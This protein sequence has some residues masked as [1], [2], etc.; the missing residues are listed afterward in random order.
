MTKK[1]G[2][3]GVGNMATAIIKG[4][5]G[6]EGIELYGVGHNKAN[7]E[8][9]KSSCSLNIIGDAAEL[10][11]RC[12]YVVIAVKP[13]HAEPVVK[14]IA[15]EMNGDK[16]LISVCAGLT[17]AIFRDWTEGR[18]PIVRVMPNTPALVGEGVAS[19]C[20]EDKKLSAEMKAFLPEVF[21]G[22]GQ[23]HVLPEKLFDAFSSVAGS[24][25]AYVFYFIE[26][27][28]ESGVTLGLARPQAT[29]MVKGLFVGSA[30]LA[31]ESDR[32]VSE[33]REM[34]TSPGGTTARALLH[35]DRQAIRG[36]IIDGV[37]KAYLR[38]IELGEQ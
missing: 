38:N 3:I 1:I 36:D 15:A 29:A 8:E 10:A 31:N 14:E 27:L 7:L 25:P 24:G 12:D 6:R 21:K 28:I 2:F 9:L 26:A 34:V 11:R 19:L 20:L 4:L 37:F 22:T 13:Q 17:Q 30:K 5:A 23:V 33:L 18:C 16:C 32:S 35:F